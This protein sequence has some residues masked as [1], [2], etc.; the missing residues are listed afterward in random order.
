MI[1]ILGLIAIG[2]VIGWYVPRPV[3]VNTA[4]NKVKDLINTIKGKFTS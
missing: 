1:K 2:V 4:V 3:I